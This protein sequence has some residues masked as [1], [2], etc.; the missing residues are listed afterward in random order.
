MYYNR[1]IKNLRKLCDDDRVL[2]DEEIKN[3]FVYV[4]GDFGKHHE[5]YEKIPI[6]PP[7]PLDSDGI[8]LCGK[9][10]VTKFGWIQHKEK[11]F[12]V[13]IG[14]K[15]IERY[16]PDCTSDH[17]LN[18]ID[19]KLCGT[20]HTRNSFYCLAC[21]KLINNT[22][23]EIWNK[24]INHIDNGNVDNQINNIRNNVVNDYEIRLLE[25]FNYNDGNV[26]DFNGRL[27]RKII[28]RAKYRFKKIKKLRKLETN[29]NLLLGKFLG[30]YI[31]QVKYFL[32][33]KSNDVDI[34]RAKE[35]YRLTKEHM[36]FKRNNPEWN[37]IWRY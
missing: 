2:S 29:R 26:K 33:Q 27:E 13:A 21:D 9:K 10:G 6:P 36:K 22:V 34:E 32:F 18:V 16:L 20:R 15:C 4:G 3:K 23:D 12:T 19:G 1:F 5:F 11:L 28:D 8:C 37:F 7:I 25:L 30:K 35:L 14:S 31:N 24:I 17:C